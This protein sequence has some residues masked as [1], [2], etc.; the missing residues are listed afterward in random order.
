M[1]RSADASLAAN[2]SSHMSANGLVIPAAANRH[3]FHELET[4]RGKTRAGA[5]AAAAG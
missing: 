4:L 5:T 3:L 2:A 1:V